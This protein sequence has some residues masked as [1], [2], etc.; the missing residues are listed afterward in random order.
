MSWMLNEDGLPSPF[1]RF[2]V[3]SS[4]C[5]CSQFLPSSHAFAR[6]GLARIP[7]DF[8]QFKSSFFLRLVMG[9]GIVNLLLAHQHLNYKRESMHDKR[10]RLVQSRSIDSSERTTGAEVRRLR[11]R[12]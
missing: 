5:S 11:S 4:F 3:S 9:D 6:H 7:R 2:A 1:I 8:V 12:P 10:I